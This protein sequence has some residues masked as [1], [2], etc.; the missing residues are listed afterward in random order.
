[1]V[2]R[3]AAA[4]INQEVNMRIFASKHRAAGGLVL[5]IL[6]LLVAC[7]GNDDGISDNKQT[8]ASDFQSDIATTSCAACGGACRELTA[9][10]TDRHHTTDHV[11]Y[12]E[13]PPVG[14]PHDGCWVPWATYTHELQTERWVHNLEHGGVVLLYSCPDGCDADIATLTSWAQSLPPGRIVVLP[15][16]EMDTGFAIVAWGVSQ[17]MSCVDTSALQ[18]FYDAHHSQSPEDTNQ[19]PPSSCPAP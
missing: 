9:V 12:P 10:I 8:P 7:A 19:D 5:P 14:G 4:V 13:Q 1:M 15:Y 18:A 2:L 6:G 17:T 11:D 16:A 3:Y